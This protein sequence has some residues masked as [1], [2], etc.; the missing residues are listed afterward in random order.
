MR[1]SSLPPPRPGTFISILSLWSPKERGWE[2]TIFLC[3][4]R[5][6]APIPVLKTQVQSLLYNLGAPVLGVG[7]T[8]PA[9]S[10]LLHRAA[11]TQGLARLQTVVWVKESVLAHVQVWAQLQAQWDLGLSWCC[12]A[13][14]PFA[15][16]PQYPHSFPPFETQVGF[17][18]A[19]QGLHGC[20]AGVWYLVGWTQEAFVY[21]LTGCNEVRPGNSPAW[22]EFWNQKLASNPSSTSFRS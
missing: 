22:C 12:Q 13:L 18:G 17:L 15:C 8:F 21:R 19:A 1:E 7:L 6:N 3:F 14:P 5:L 9:L 10:Y 2:I 4:M 16:A 20:P 11:T